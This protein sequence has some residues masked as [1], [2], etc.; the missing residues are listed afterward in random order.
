MS[1]YLKIN[2]VQEPTDLMKTNMKKLLALLLLFGIVGCSKE[3]KEMVVEPSLLDKCIA[4]NIT[5]LQDLS[6]ENEAIDS[7]KI[8]IPEGSYHLFGVIM[9]KEEFTK[10]ALAAFDVNA[11]SLSSELC[12]AIDE[13]NK[14]SEIKDC[15]RV[16]QLTADLFDTG[17]LSNVD[18]WIESSECNTKFNKRDIEVVEEC[19]AQPEESI[20][21]TFIPMMLTETNNI[22]EEAD[23]TLK[24]IRLEMI[25]NG[26]VMDDDSRALLNET[27]KH[28]SEVINREAKLVCNAQGIY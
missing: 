21:D 15:E 17:N 9:T 27:Y 5:A 13:L 28:Y 20:I 12:E 11:E 6:I 14:S 8:Y 3:S 22:F 7:L 16:A 4:S 23:P 24:I 25:S 10:K 19:L 26:D 2:L 18:Y 1:L